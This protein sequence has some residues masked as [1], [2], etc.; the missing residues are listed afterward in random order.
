MNNSQQKDLIERGFAALGFSV[1]FWNSKPSANGQDCFVQKWGK[2]PMSVEVKKVRKLS[3]GTSQCEPVSNDRKKDD[4][5]A[6][7]LNREYVF[8]DSMEN[9]LKCCSPKGTRQFTWEQ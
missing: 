5:I 1:V 3:N 8:I 2:R 7:I 9:H 4:L 6:I